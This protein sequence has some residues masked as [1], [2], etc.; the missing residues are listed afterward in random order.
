MGA[1][2]SDWVVQVPIWPRG[3]GVKFPNRRDPRGTRDQSLS[4]TL[5]AAVIQVHKNGSSPPLLKLARARG[6]GFQ[7]GGSNVTN[8]PSVS[9]WV[10]QVPLSPSGVGVGLWNRPPGIYSRMV[11]YN[12]LD[13][14]S[15]VAKSM[16]DITQLVCE[17]RQQAIIC[18]NGGLVP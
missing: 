6:L 10:V 18:I 17:N 4:V 14:D 3:L 11:R 5:V 12:G 8:Q 9:D 7:K 16:T 13:L 2:V 1:N 15:D